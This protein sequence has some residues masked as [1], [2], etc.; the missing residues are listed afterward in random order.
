MLRCF[1][2]VLASQGRRLSRARR[3][4]VVGGERPA[5]E[6][7]APRAFFGRPGGAGAGD[8]PAAGIGAGRVVEFD[9]LPRAR[10]VGALEAVS[11]AEGRGRA[12]GTGQDLDLQVSYQAGPSPV[13]NGGWE[14]DQVVCQRGDVK[15]QGIQNP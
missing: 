4:A 5:H 10:T 9:R 1:S 12:R 11:H 6:D 8:G 15:D 2:G 3:V 14:P 7:H 13:L